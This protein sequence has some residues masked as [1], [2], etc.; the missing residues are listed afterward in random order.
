M[1]KVINF[2][3]T[4]TQPTRENSYAPLLPN[5]I[6]EVV[7]QANEIGISIVH[8]HARN[9]ETLEKYKNLIVIKSIS[10]SFGVA[11]IRLGVMASSDKDLLKKIK[12]NFP[13]WNINSFAESFLQKITYNL[14]DYRKSCSKLLETKKDFQNNLSSLDIK[15][16]NSQANFFMIKLPS[17]T[18]SK[19]FAD[20]M[21]KNNIL[22]KVLD[23]KS[24]IPEGNFLRLS[25]KSEDQ[26]KAF[27]Y[28][29]KEY[30]DGLKK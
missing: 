17:Y 14:S 9:E 22:V 20:H 30:F 5:E 13:V 19:D 1:K 25:I 12:E 24:G 27:V 29:A 6:I 3:P 16:Y 8:L 4:G 28:I 15:V 21:I 26:N 23:G 10:K 2:T 7:H 11:G 18:S